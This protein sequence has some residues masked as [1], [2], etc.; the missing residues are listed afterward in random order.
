MASPQHQPLFSLKQS[1]LYAL[2]Q[3]I[4]VGCSRENLDF[5]ECKAELTHPSECRVQGERV[6]D[7]ISVMYSHLLPLLSLLYFLS[8]FSPSKLTH[9]FLT[10]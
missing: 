8:Y 2:S 10:C 6:F 1:A 7:C 9:H 4:N 5:S 3:L